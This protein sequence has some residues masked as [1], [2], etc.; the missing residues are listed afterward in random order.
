MNKIKVKR[1]IIILIN[2][3]EQ[4]QKKIID[5]EFFINISFLLLCKH[6]II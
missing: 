2:Y 6:L 3:Q 5:Y 4:I 1:I